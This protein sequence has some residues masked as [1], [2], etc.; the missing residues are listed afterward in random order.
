MTGGQC[1]YVTYQFS[2]KSNCLFLRR[3][4]DFVNVLTDNGRQTTDNR[5]RTKDDGQQTTG[6]RQRTTDDG[7]QTTDDR[8][9]TVDNGRYTTDDRQRTAAYCII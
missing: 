2:S 3:V 5:R 6:G 1:Q 8:R 4:F 7:R 9:R